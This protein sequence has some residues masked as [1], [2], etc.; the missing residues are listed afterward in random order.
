MF[1]SLARRRAFP[2]ARANAAPAGPQARALKST[3]EAGPRAPGVRVSHTATRPHHI[4]EQRIR[5]DDAA[6]LERDARMSTLRIC[7][8]RGDV[9]R[10]VPAR[11]EKQGL[12][13]D[14]ARTRSHT[15]VDGPRQAGLANFHVGEAHARLLASAHLHQPSDLF[16]HL[17]RRAVSAAVVHDHDRLLNAARGSCRGS[18][19]HRVLCRNGAVCEPK[20]APLYFSHPRY[21]SSTPR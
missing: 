8:E 1:A 16:D 14:L 4:R 19:V 7:D 18:P 6:Q 15:V 17:V 3:R 2:R 10:G 9:A 12:H 5:T 11:G 21:G 20:P 13:H